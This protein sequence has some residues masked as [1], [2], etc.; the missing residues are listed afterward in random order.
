MF[1]TVILVAC[2]QPTDWALKTQESDL[3]VVEGRITSERRAHLVKLHY[4]NSTLNSAPRPV[5]EAVVYLSGNDTLYT[6]TED[7]LHAGNYYTPDNVQGFT[8]REYLLII[9]W[10]GKNYSA[11]DRMNPGSFLASPVFVASQKYPG[12][13][14]YAA[15]DNGSEYL[16]EL[17]A[18]PEGIVIGKAPAPSAVWYYYSLPS[19]D[20][21]RWFAPQKEVVALSP[22]T[23]IVRRQYSLSEGYIDFLR[24]LLAETEWRGGLFDVAH[25]NVKTNLSAGAVGYFSAHM[26]TTDTIVVE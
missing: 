12:Q 20:V 1:L 14:E 3:L 19:V 15:P 13:F 6:L 22:G 7:T 18:Y 8:G 25:A 2:E 16:L 5:S 9:E 26:V 10:K 4:T 17:A 11:T 21:S 23:I 24:S